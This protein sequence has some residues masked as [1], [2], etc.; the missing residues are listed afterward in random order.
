MVR[1]KEPEVGKRES[2]REG[3]RN[4]KEWKRERDLHI[5]IYIDRK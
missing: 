5:Y 3:E 4:E 1:K 2:D